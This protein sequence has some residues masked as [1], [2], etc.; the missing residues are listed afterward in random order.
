MENLNGK[1]VINI[2]IWLTDIEKNQK[3]L[4]IKYNGF[5][6]LFKSF[7]Q[8]CLDL[9]EK[10]GD[11]RPIYF[12]VQHFEWLK[13]ILEAYQQSLHQLLIIPNTA[14]TIQ[15]QLSEEILRL[16]TIRQKLAKVLMSEN[17]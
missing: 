11:K 17:A 13:A 14:K 2:Y 12:S 7:H 10:E 1:D 6:D 15:D 3:D 9:V 5:Y 4:V 16:V 8:S